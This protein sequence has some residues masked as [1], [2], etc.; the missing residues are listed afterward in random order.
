VSSEPKPWVPA[1]AAREWG[2]YTYARA[3]EVSAPLLLPIGD[4]L[5]EWL[6]RQTDLP[7]IVITGARLRVRAR[8]CQR[9]GASTR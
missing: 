2:A 8:A 4:A 9:Q 3:I 1:E 7:D 5:L 6:A